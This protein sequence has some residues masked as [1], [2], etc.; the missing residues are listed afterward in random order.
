MNKN[1]TEVGD[2]IRIVTYRK[3]EVLLHVLLK[4]RCS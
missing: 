3:L 2:G 4:N 1:D